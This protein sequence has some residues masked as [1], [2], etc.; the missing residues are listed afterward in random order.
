MIRLRVLGDG[1]TPS[2]SQMER[3]IRRLGLMLKTWQ[4]T[5]PKLYTRAEQTV[6]LVDGTQSYT[7]TTRPASVQNVRWAVDGVER[8]PLAKWSRED[9]D[10]MPQKTAE[11]SPKIYVLDRQISGTSLTIWNVP[12]I[13]DGEAWTLIVSYERVPYDVTDSSE[14]IDVPQEWH[15]FVIDSLG[16]LLSDEF[17]V[18]GDHVTRMGQRVAAFGIALLGYERDGE[19]RFYTEA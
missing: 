1:E 8:Y 6:T 15:D 18:T 11:G 13:P 16:L 17:G 4:I 10:A 12:D 9:W 19:I 14:T 3:G 5:G 7:L 2:S